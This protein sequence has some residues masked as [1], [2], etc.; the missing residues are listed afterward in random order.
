M[1]RPIGG[2][3]PLG[4]PTPPTGWPIGSYPTYAEAQKAVDY[5]SDHQFPV[6][7][8]TIV[9]VDLMQVERIVGRL[10]WPRVIGGA[11]VAGAW[12]GVFIGLLIGIFTG[13]ILGA[14]LTG[15]TFGVMF[16][17][18]MQS[19][20]YA[21]SRGQRDFQSTMQLVAGRYD[22]LCDPR[23]AEQGRDLLAQLSHAH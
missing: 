8:V 18:I 13:Q 20:Q 22:V 11:V 5:L 16:W 12:I 9:G 3:K 21:A 6:R 4:L 10:N 15:I 1:T 2:A 7:D 14:L 23:T 17:V 19:V